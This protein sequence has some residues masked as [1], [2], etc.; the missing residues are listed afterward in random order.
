[1]RP[2]SCFAVENKLSEEADAP[3]LKV[4]LKF[5]SLD[6]FSPEQVADKVKPL[7]PHLEPRSN[8]GDLAGTLQTNDALDQLLLEAVNNTEKRDQLRA[9]LGIG[10]RPGGPAATE[11]GNE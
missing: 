4:D 7:Q 11:V 6:D 8:L 2:H 10:N 5:E 3:Q 1:M 9:E